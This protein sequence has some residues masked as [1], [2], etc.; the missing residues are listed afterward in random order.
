MD[1]ISQSSFKTVDIQKVAGTINSST[2]NFK[3]KDKVEYVGPFP[4]VVLPQF[5]Q[6]SSALQPKIQR[7]LSV[8]PIDGKVRDLEEV[9]KKLK[10]DLK[11]ARKEHEKLRKSVEE[12]GKGV[13]E[14]VAK[15]ETA[16][17]E[18]ERIK[19][20]NKMLKLIDN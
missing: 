14:W 11:E 12:S 2:A 15:M 6:T 19:E 10:E 9:N 18:L 5:P 4:E 13:E 1:M 7:E 20:N 16:R 3:K 17:L 8:S